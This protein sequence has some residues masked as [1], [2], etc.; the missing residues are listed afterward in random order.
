M[1]DDVAYVLMEETPGGLYPL[2]DGGRPSGTPVHLQ[3]ITRFADRTRGV[4]IETVWS[5]VDVA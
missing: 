1:N 5:S 2:R 3:R 4:L